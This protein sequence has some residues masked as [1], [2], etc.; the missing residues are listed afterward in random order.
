MRH[1]YD[2]SRLCSLEEVS[3]FVGTEAYQECVIDVKRICLESFADQA[4]P[5]GNA[6]PNSPAFTVTAETFSVL[7]VN[8]KREAE[9]FFSEPPSLKSIF[10]DIQKLLPNL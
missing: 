1:Y 7:E 8:Y 10:A 6:L 4:V 9:I 2:L 5:D 3:S